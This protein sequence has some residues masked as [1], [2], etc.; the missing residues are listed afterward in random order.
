LPRSVEI[1]KGVEESYPDIYTPDAL[2]AIEAL[3][4]FD[5]DRKAVNVSESS[6]ESGV[7]VY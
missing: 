7:T 4:T 1:R 3:A 2:A 5:D 6:N